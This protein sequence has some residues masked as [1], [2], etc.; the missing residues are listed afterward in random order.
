MAPGTAAETESGETASV[1]RIMPR[2]IDL[3]R[4]FRNKKL[5]FSFLTK[6]RSSDKISR[7]LNKRY[8]DILDLRKDKDNRIYMR[9]NRNGR[10]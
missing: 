8:L 10:K 7:Y 5:I 3:P 6:Q 2:E 9:R 4:F 1:E